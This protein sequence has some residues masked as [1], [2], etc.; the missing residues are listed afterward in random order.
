MWQQI[1]RTRPS[2][3]PM[4]P[5]HHPTHSS[6]TLQ[7]FYRLIAL[8][9]WCPP[10]IALPVPLVLFAQPTLA[11]KQR[12]K[13]STPGRHQ[14]L[15]MRR[16][17]LEKQKSRCFWHLCECGCHHSLICFLVSAAATTTT[18][19]QSKIPP[20]S[21]HQHLDRLL[22]SSSGGVVIVAGAIIVC[23]APAVRQYYA[24]ATLF[25]P[26]PAPLACFSLLFATD[27]ARSRKQLLCAHLA[28]LLFA[29]CGF[30]SPCKWYWILFPFYPFFLS[31]FLPLLGSFML[32]TGPNFLGP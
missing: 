7:G 1:I 14:S 31:P 2:G 28:R 8:A 25:S 12:G 15:A 32:R 13:R 21:N 26:V 11:P 19:K 27:L 4:F 5:A 6:S 18:K 20:S 22:P 29:V 23:L 24:P 30:E 16:E 10:A 3:S 9:Q 17:F